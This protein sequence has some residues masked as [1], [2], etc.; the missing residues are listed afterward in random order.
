MKLKIAISRKNLFVLSG[1]IN[2]IL[3][4]LIVSKY[5]DTSSEPPKTIQPSARRPINELSALKGL[6][7]EGRDTIKL[8]LVQSEGSE[9]VLMPWFF[10]RQVLGRSAFVPISGGT[11]SSGLQEMLQMS[12]EEVAALQ[13][14]SARLLKMVKQSEKERAK[15]IVD[16]KG[17]TFFELPPAPAFAAEIRASMTEKMYSVLGDERGGFASSLL[18]DGDP[19][20]QSGEDKLEISIEEVNGSPVFAIRAFPL[21]GEAT[22]S[23]KPL[24]R[25]NL[26]QLEHRYGHIFDFVAWRNFLDNRSIELQ[27]GDVNESGIFDGL[28]SIR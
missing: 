23:G 22:G 27:E 13:D 20:F 5:S 25:F 1:T 17:S 4:F 8:N 9:T 15:L 11:I 10:A 19:F 2:C 6:G 12:D 26:A 3:L 28:P 24:D 7:A 16:E 18:I 14:E 21:D